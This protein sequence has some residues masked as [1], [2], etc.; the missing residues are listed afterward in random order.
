[1]VTE[2]CQNGL[3]KCLSLMI[4]GLPAC[5]WFSLQVRGLRL[6]EEEGQKSIIIY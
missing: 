6:G 4:S 5:Y 3:L 1:M 2:S